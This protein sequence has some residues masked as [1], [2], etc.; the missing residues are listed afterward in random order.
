M[1][2][3]ATHLVRQC[4]TWLWRNNSLSGSG[5]GHMQNHFLIL[6]S[7]VVRT[8]NCSPMPAPHGTLCYAVFFSSLWTFQSIFV[9]RQLHWVEAANLLRWLTAV[10][11]NHR[12]LLGTMGPDYSLSVLWVPRKTRTFLTRTQIW[13]LWKDRGPSRVGFKNVRFQNWQAAA[14]RGAGLLKMAVY[15]GLWHVFATEYVKLKYFLLAKSWTKIN[16]QHYYIPL[17]IHFQ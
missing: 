9:V 5:E 2:F 6:T 8:R 15:H 16:Q 10:T 13:F 17:Y 11:A 14:F 1:T 3:L 4:I 12:V 7:A